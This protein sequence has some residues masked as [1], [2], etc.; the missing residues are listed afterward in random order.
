MGIKAKVFEQFVNEKNLQVVVADEYVVNFRVSYQYGKGGLTALANTS[1]DLDKLI[2]S[3]A[4]ETAIGKDLEDA[5][6]SQLEGRRQ[7][8]RVEQDHGHNGAG[9]GFYLI[10]DDIL[11]LL[12][13]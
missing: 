6:N 10:L 12:N 5:I 2:A 3:G 13:K 7:L 9:Y 8:I 4:S 1:K 11:K